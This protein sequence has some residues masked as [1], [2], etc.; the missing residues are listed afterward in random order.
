[1]VFEKFHSE[2]KKIQGKSSLEFDLNGVPPSKS[3]RI[4]EVIEEALKMS[5][6]E[7]ENENAT[8]KDKIK[9]L[10]ITLMH[11]PIF[12]SPIAKIQPW[13]SFEGTP[14]SNSS[15]RGTSSLLVAAKRYVGENIKKKMSLVLKTWKLEN[16]FISLGPR[17]KNLRQYLQVDLEND[18]E[19]YK[20]VFSTFVMKMMRNF[21]KELFP[22]LL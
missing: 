5:V 12:L 9:E 7:M 10:E 1:L 13:K 21:I 19:F 11:P 4:H 18:E 8:L 20:G 14:K 16:N 3:V 6:D 22:P 2:N 17:M 15:L